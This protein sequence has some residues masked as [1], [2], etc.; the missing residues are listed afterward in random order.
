MKKMI[1]TTLLALCGL[2]VYA[3]SAD[4]ADIKKVCEAETRTWID[5][6][7]SGHAACWHVQP[8]SS[9]CVSLADGTLINMSGAD[10]MKNEKKTMG[11]GG[12]FTNSNYIIKVSG[13]MAWATFDQ[14]GANPKGQQ[15]TSKE[16]R[17]LEKVKGTWKIVVVNAHLYQTK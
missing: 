7:E 9:L 1:L 14:V 5:G 6:D 2:F 10:L 4:E 16:L 11:G 8:Y 13:D 17:I 3:Q 15:K 12:T